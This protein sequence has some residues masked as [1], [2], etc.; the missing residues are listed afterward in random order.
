MITRLKE[1]DEF[2]YFKLAVL[3]LKNR[4]ANLFN[5]LY[6][7]LTETNRNFFHEVLQ[8]KRVLIENDSHTTNEARKIVKVKK[9]KKI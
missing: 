8:T 3:E 7:E 6:S 2:E 1:M 9:K 4:N 5:F